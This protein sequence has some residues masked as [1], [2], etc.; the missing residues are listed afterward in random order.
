MRVIKILY[1]DNHLLVVAKPAGLLVQGDRSGDVTLLDQAKEYLKVKYAKPGNVYL[2][3]VHRLDRNV[4]GAVILART[5]KAAGR[6]SAQFRAGTITKSYLAIVAGNPPDGPQILH[7]WLAAKGDAHGVTRAAPEPF[8]GA[9]EAVLEYSVRQRSQGR[10]LL[11]V[12]P[13]TGRRH[14]I[15]AQLAQAGW[16]LLGDVKYGARSAL[17]QRRIGLHALGVV[18]QHPVREDELEIVCK[19]PVDWPWVNQEY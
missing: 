10:T 19:P 15:R 7:G 11:D 17:P 12:H 18:F 6:L 5:S 16:P 14:Q 1:E 3:L 13:V 8:S 2:G 9:K 4:S